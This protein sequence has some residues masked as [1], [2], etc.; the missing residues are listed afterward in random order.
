MKRSFFAFLCGFVLA[1]SSPA[2][3]GVVT[4]TS[5]PLGG[6]TFLYELTLNNEFAVPVSGLNLLHANTAFGLDFSSTIGAPAGWSF[7]PPLPPLVDELNFFSLSPSSDVVP[8]GSLGGFSFESNRDPST[9]LGNEFVADLINANNGSQI[10]EPPVLALLEG[11]CLVLGLR[12]W[13]RHA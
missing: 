5:T 4:W 6:G 7:F 9:L 11:A 13:I 2:R 3:A 1:L 10:P 12:R 8:G